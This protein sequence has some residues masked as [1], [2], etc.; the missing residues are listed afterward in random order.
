M[1][2]NDRL[3]LIF[4]VLGPL[5]GGLGLMLPLAALL[6]ITDREQIVSYYWMPGLMIAYVVGIV[7]GFITAL[8]TIATTW[9]ATAFLRIL[10]ASAIGFV[11]SLSSLLLLSFAQG[12]EFP[13]PYR[14]DEIP[15]ALAGIVVFLGWP[16]GIAALACMT[17]VEFLH[18]QVQ[19]S[20]PTP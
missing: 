20:H 13:L 12:S 2:R 7:P 11:V 10:V 14:P 4:A 18:P 9:L 5:I 6:M 17:V 16:G 3:I 15:L 1:K 19:P 8:L